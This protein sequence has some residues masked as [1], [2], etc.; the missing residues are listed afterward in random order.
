MLRAGVVR[1]RT[2]ALL[3]HWWAYLRGRL[4]VERS[5]RYSFALG[6]VATTLV[7]VYTYVAV[8]LGPAVE[9]NPLMGW[10]IEAHGWVAFAAVR[11]AVVG[12]VFLLLWPFARLEGSWPEWSEGN[13]RMAAAVLGLNAV[14]DGFVVHTGIVPTYVLLRALGLL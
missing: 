14:R 3:G 6:M 5:L 11:Y 7:T 4:D 2:V 1:E 8:G 12:G 10:L 13:G 9:A